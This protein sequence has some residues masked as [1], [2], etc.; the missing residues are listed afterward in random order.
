MSFVEETVGTDAYRLDIMYGPDQ[1]RW[2]SVLKKNGSDVKT[3]IFGRYYE[4][5][6]QNGVTRELACQPD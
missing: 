1:Q 2:K 6:S 3:I 4:K 5:V